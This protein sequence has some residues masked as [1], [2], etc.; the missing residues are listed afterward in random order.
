MSKMLLEDYN[1]L[2]KEMPDSPGV[3][4]FLGPRKEVLY[5]GKATSLKSRVRSYFAPDLIETRGPLLVEML[6]L[7]KNV[8]WKQADSVLEAL[9]L[10]ANLIRSHQ[11]P[12]NT[13]LKDDKSFNYVVITKE[14]FPRV[15]VVRGK[16]LE[17]EFPEKKRKYV[18]GPFPHGLQLREA[19]KLVRKIF[20]YRDTCT[21]AADL[22]AQGKKPRP[23]FNA[24]IG[25]C[26]GVCSGAISKEEY[27]RI[28]RHIALL[29]EGKKKQLLKTLER[30]MK[31]AAKAERFEEAARMRGQ[32]FALTHIQDVSLIKE[33]Y[34]KPKITLG[35]TRI[36][37][38]DMAHLRGSANVGV[39]T[40]VE[41]GVAQRSDYRK[42]RI[43][44][45]SP[46][47]DVGALREVLTRRLGHEEWPLPRLI[48]VDGA[49]AQMNAA[50]KVLDEFGMTIPIV[51]V[52]K[53]EKHRPRDIRGDRE[54]IQGRERDI[55]LANA[56]AHR[57]AINYHRKTSRKG[58]TEIG[59]SERTIR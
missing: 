21:P 54:L 41:D 49:A 24:H 5:I 9:I 46:G 56:E 50:Q 16:N 17:D 36:E 22:M 51:G 38:Y 52:V 44:A 2:K 32:V 23:C 30:E 15:L 1:N 47:D 3:Y 8:E 19:M 45:A 57:F 55:L 28:I 33:E 48:A 29:F 58:L 6:A 31:A 35:V 20:P 12:Y 13:L 59:W 7:A 18:F 14:D 39:M 11:P 53:D 4:Y 27:A 10:E 37:A 42:F 25:L 34:R 26:P 40:V 43:R